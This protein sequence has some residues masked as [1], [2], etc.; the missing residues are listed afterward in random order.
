MYI[1]IDCGTQGTK[2]IVVDFSQ[3][4]VIGIGYAKHDLIEQS[5]GRREQHPNWWIEAL[6]QALEIALRQAKK[7]PHFS[8]NLVKGIGISGQQHG[9]VI[10]DKYDQPLYNAKL[11][12][13]TETTD[14][15]DELI[16]KLRGQKAAFEKLGIMCQTGYTAS[17]LMW[18]RKHY[19]EQ[20]TQIKK[21]MLPHDY[22]NYWL[23]GNFCTEFGDASGTGYFDIINRKWSNEVFSK[24]APELVMN[25]VL[26]TLLSAEK[27]LG[28]LK[29]EIAALFG[30]NKS[31]TVSTGGGDNMMG[32]IGTGNIHEGIATMS[33]GTSG[34]LYASTNHFLSNLPPMIANFCSS[35]NGWLPLICVMNMTSSNK[36]LMNL[37]QID[38]NEF[39]LLAQQSP[40]GANGITVLPFFNGERVPPLPN[41]KASILGLDSSNF[42]RE[43][44]CRAMMES[45]TFTLRYGLDLFRQAGLNTSQIRLIGGGSK[46]AL[47]RQMIS[48]VMN[49]EVVCLQEDE[50]A[51]LGGAIQAMWANGEGELKS[52]CEN[53]I[54]LDENSRTYPNQLRVASYQEIYNRYIKTLEMIH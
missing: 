45:T 37:F 12:C 43:N 3:R 23:T 1:G 24:I 42:T 31:V 52:L 13:D 14:E 8:P 51:A 7:S 47:W 38:I 5:N 11:W 39:N 48:D 44:L 21:V 20:F 17:K 18:F 54:H 22:L 25:D 19:P 49:A 35:S 15:N 41:A 50:A 16:E 34:T 27:K 2:A 46:S 32:A 53:F 30:F 28:V 36:Q 4:K 26:P 29:P 9:L 33:L 40:I 6:K 10:L